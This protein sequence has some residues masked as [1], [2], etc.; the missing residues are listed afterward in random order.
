MKRL[1]LVILLLYNGFFLPA[2]AQ[3]RIQVQGIIQMPEEEDVSGISIFN[4][5]SGR[6]TLS[7]DQGR[8]NMGVALND[9]IRIRAVQFQEFTVV[10]DEGV[11]NTGELNISI[12]EVVNLLPEVIVSPYDLTGNVRVDITRLQVARVP[13][14]IS[15]LG[16]QN[17]YFEADAAPNY[18]A[19]PENITLPIHVTGMKDG[20]NF[21]NIFRS[22]LINR[23]RDQVQLVDTTLTTEIRAL[24]NDEFFKENLNIEL[25]NIND[26][27]FYADEHGL[28]EHMLKE[29]NE[30]DLIEFLVN[31]SKK[32]KRERARN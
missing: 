15:S 19:P 28:E 4:V 18:N 17:M 5:N 10:V 6:G 26:F 9:S 8:F 3:E 32:Y 13:D 16:S 1:T 20:L 27:I 22:I 2:Q 12:S 25:E 7:N 30:L 29:G 14:T 23:K 21:A 11:I 31:K 24:Y